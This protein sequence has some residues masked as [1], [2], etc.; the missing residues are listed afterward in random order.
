MLYLLGAIFCS[1]IIPTIFRFAQIKKCKQAPV[2][3]FNYVMCLLIVA[4]SY[5]TSKNYLPVNISG[6]YGRSL[7]LSVA[8]GIVCGALYYFG[9]FFYQKS[10][11]VSG[12]AMSSAFGKMG[13]IIPVA[14]SAVFWKEYPTW[15]AA[16]GIALALCAVALSYFDFKSFSFTKLHL[17][18]IV[19]FFIGGLADFTNKI[20]QKY[21]LAQHEM[22]FLFFVFLSAL[23]FSLKETI[24][25]K[26]P[27]K[28]EILIGLSLGI[29][30]MLTAFFIIRALYLL[31]AF[32]V[33][34]MFSGGTILLALILSLILYKDMPSK[35][36]IISIFM[37]VVALI[38]LNI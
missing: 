4:A 9:F 36:Q 3:S 25:D 31:P 32:I 12:A 17:V 33:F 23:I 6:E 2:L 35:K 24:S 26:K 38:M 14:L 5:F 16:I 15:F 34:P 22:F 20:F 7:I 30:N 8:I 19:F 28:K 37:I 1:A 29:P 27:D 18:L 21:C 10:V 13:V 11:S